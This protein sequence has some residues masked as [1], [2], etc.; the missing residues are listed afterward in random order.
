MSSVR[1]DIIHGVSWTAIESF[2]NTGVGFILG[3]ILARLLTPEDY[4][5][6]GMVGIFISISVIFIDGGFGQ[7]LIQKQHPT[8]E[9]RSTVFFFN[10]GVAIIC[11]IIL[12]FAAPWIASFLNTPVLTGILRVLGISLL[13]GSVGGVQYNLLS[14]A[15]D[16]RS[17][18]IISISGSV[19]QGII[20]VTMAYHG[21]GPWAIV[22]PSVF[23]TTYGVV[24]VWIVS[25]WRPKLVFSKKSFKEM[26]SF[27][28]NLVVNSL[29]D[30]LL[31]NGTNLL[32]GKF[33]TPKQLGYYS[34]G[35]STANT[36]ASIINTILGKVMFPVFSKIN[37]D[38]TYLVHVYRRYLRIT[39]MVIFFFVVMVAALGRPFTVFLYSSRWLPSVFFMQIT[40]IAV[41]LGH[42]NG[43]NWALIR[44]HKRTDIALRKEVIIKT[45]KFVALA[46]AIPFG[47][48]A[49]CWSVVAGAVFS[50]IVN[51]IV[52]AKISPYSYKEQISDFVPYILKAVI[53]NIPAFFITYLPLP[54]IVILILGGLVS[55]SLY[56]LLLR[57]THDENFSTLLG[58]IP[59]NKFLPETLSAR[60]KG[61]SQDH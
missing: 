43:L 28:G 32:I 51:T 8:D 6:V 35:Q 37:D 14:K 45:F 5:T 29:L 40:C 36:P 7:A 61:Q 15:I 9:D 47:V 26:F 13:V 38:E 25:K 57:M 16:F 3:I 33:Y 41:M 53:V 4:G 11:Y 22:I 58:L 12:F 44:A 31:G 52:T 18:A 27:G 48:V 19:L 46:V 24:G 55:C 1:Q 39:S 17:Q 20:G 23:T 49:I 59:W 56:V 34:K 21:Y 50:I 54:S 2:A 30:T 42:V 60:I 10:V